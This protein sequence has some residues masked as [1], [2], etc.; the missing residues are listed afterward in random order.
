[1]CS[2]FNSS[3][4]VLFFQKKVS[5]DSVCLSYNLSI[6]SST[7]FNSDTSLCTNVRIILPT[8]ILTPSTVLGRVERSFPLCPFYTFRSF[9]HH[10][11][12]QFYHILVL[13][14]QFSFFASPLQIT[15]LSLHDLSFMFRYV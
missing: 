9:S 8:Q 10:I 11:F 6:S 15:S 7:C 14:F 4:F 12:V 3:M 13:Q 5:K 2:K 1:M